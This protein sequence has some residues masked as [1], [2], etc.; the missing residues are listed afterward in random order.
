[1][2]DDA[3]EAAQPSRRLTPSAGTEAVSDRARATSD[4]PSDANEDFLF[5]LYR[6]SELLQDDRAHEAKE[7]LER[8]LH[9]QPHDTKGQDLLAVVYFRLGLFPRAISILEQL[10]R[11]NPK[12]TAILLNLSL[13]FLKTGQPSLAR[14]D[15]EALIAL[16]PN[17]NRA[18]GYLGLACERLGA[19]A[20]AETAFTRGNHAQM[21]KRMAERRAIQG[22]IVPP[23]TL[24]S[25]LDVADAAAR[26]VVATA[27]EE[28]D[29]GE[30]SFKLAESAE[31]SAAADEAAQSWRPIE[32]GN[33]TEKLATNIGEPAISHAQNVAV[34]VQPRP[35]TRTMAAASMPIMHEK[36]ESNA[37]KERLL[38]AIPQL[39]PPSHSRRPTLIAPAPPHANPDPSMKFPSSRP[40]PFTL[41]D[42]GAP[43]YAAASSPNPSPSV[44]HP[45]VAV[46]PVRR[47]PRLSPPPQLAREGRV[48]TL[49][50]P[51][52][53]APGTKV[54]GIVQPSGVAIVKIV[55]GHGF[56]VRLEAIRASA[57][58]LV[59]KTLDRH[60][61]GRTTGES[62]GGVA[63]P[64]VNVTGDG[65]LVLAPRAGR[66]LASHVLDDEMC[67]LREDVLFGFDD[68][69][70]YEN[71]RLSTGD[72]ELMA[73][74]Q[75]RG[76]GLV[77][78]E[79]IG[80]AIGIDVQPSRG[81]HVRREAVLGWFG[82]LVPRALPPNEAPAGQRGLVSFAGEGRV[83]VAT[84]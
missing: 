18:W 72:G 59:M 63:S 16:N 83:L 69:L 2:T 25:G 1:M 82:R 68:S 84:S 48:P 34:T 66:E 75:L 76:K 45:V 61:K 40:L 29:A 81:I 64:I 9:L 55:D 41:D 17:H 6:G 8:A 32:L 23:N 58:G 80:A 50:P 22:S 21:A 31:S 42:A 35:I 56:S 52:I 11:K 54:D 71:G 38:P 57:S 12:D 26:N 20:E 10:R 60:V 14:R 13:C 39:A 28:L 3:E 51:S 44:R 73:I 49:P 47:D 46:P 53:A 65:Q 15:L 33:L 27:F 36:K 30:L 37:P 62:F 43:S 70:P 7:E 24:E 74:V 67:F 79:S 19:L 5:H 77:L 78:L 4:V